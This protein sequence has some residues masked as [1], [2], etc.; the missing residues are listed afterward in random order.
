MLF[1]DR[2]TVTTSRQ[3]LSTLN[4]VNIFTVPCGNTHIT[5]QIFLL[6]N[7]PFLLAALLPLCT[8]PRTDPDNSRLTLQHISSPFS[9]TT[10]LLS[11]LWSTHKI[12]P[13]VPPY[14]GEPRRRT[15]HILVTPTRNT[16][17]IGDPRW[18]TFHILVNPNEERS[19]NWWPLRR[20]LHIFVNPDEEHS[21]YWWPQRR[22]L[23][24]LFSG[25][26]DGD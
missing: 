22:T 24:N 13:R 12:R 25:P 4:G 15:L 23:H 6:F 21:I 26:L 11:S 1:R 3:S 18:R 5:A 14:V 19:L 7:S 9:L 20:T 17:Y 8:T 10:K 2:R 16:P